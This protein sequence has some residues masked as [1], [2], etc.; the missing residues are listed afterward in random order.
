MSSCRGFICVSIPLLWGVSVP[1][2]ANQVDEAGNLIATAREA[3]M[4]GKGFLYYPPR[5]VRKTAAAAPKTD[6]KADT[7]ADT[8]N[9]P[10][11][12]TPKSLAPADLSKTEVVQVQAPEVSP[13]PPTPAA[14]PA[15]TPEPVPLLTVRP[16][17]AR[18]KILVTNPRN[19]LAGPAEFAKASAYAGSGTSVVVGLNMPLPDGGQYR[20]EW[21]DGF[22]A[23]QANK[24]YGGSTY[25]TTRDEQHLGVFMDWSPN[26]NNW[27][28]TGGLTL[29][30]HRIKVQTTADAS[31]AIEY[32]LPLL[33]PY[34]GVRYA[35]KSFND[36]GWEGFA[37]V[38]MLLATLNASST[39]DGSVSDTT[40]QSEVDRIRKSI[41]Q[42]SFVPKA[43]VGLSYKY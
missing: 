32:K 36:R 1:V 27:F 17:L 16:A 25:K 14:E 2:W 18:E 20:V 22:I 42:W 10:E 3:E 43:V 19:R 38:G 26:D 37:E 35:Q 11:P 40:V 7:K 31:L 6:T 4:M 15:P 30:N 34:V 39:T 29:N 24:S 33:T 41:Y 5:V 23:P 9:P 12:E 13:A 28:L 21:S 8:K